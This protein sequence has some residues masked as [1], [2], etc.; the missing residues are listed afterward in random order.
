[1]NDPLGIR[2]LSSGT[3]AT[4]MRQSCRFLLYQGS[5]GWWID[6]VQLHFLWFSRTGTWPQWQDCWDAYLRLLERWDDSRYCSYMGETDVLWQGQ[7]YVLGSSF[8]PTWP[9]WNGQDVIEGRLAT[10]GAVYCKHSPADSFP[11]DEVIAACIGYV[12]VHAA[13][14]R[15]P[16]PDSILGYD[17]VNWRYIHHEAFGKPEHGVPANPI[18]GYVYA[19]AF[20]DYNRVA[21]WEEEPIRKRLPAGVRS[22]VD[23]S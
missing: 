12:P 2:V 20:V 13:Y 11:P 5:D 14:D 22:A 19:R 21:N 8:D 4:L 9:H 15:R 10:L 7:R 18:N 3:I 6:K 17:I 23:A 16:N 1:M